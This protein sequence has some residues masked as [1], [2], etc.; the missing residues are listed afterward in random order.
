ME[1]LADASH[2]HRGASGATPTAESR[3][4]SHKSGKGAT[5]I[6]LGPLCGLNSGPHE[7]CPYHGHAQ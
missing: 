5:L 1:H 4:M 3:Y 6:D 2:G 7:D